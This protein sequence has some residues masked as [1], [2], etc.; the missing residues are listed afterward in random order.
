MLL[1]LLCS[2]NYVSYNVKVAQIMGLNTAVYLSELIN[3]N[4]KAINKDKIDNNCFTINRQYIENR[5]TISIE[6]QLKLDKKLQ[7]VGILGRNTDNSDMVYIDVNSL[8]NMIA[9]GDAK[10]LERVTKLTKLKDV[11]NMKVGKMTQKQRD[12]ENCKTAISTT[13]EELRTALCGWIEGVFAR[14]N[15]FLSKRA[16][17]IFQNELYKYTNGDLDL[18]LKLV[19]ISTVGGYRNFEWAREEFETK[20]ADSFRRQYKQTPIKVKT[21]ESVGEVFE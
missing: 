19:D 17:T 6:E 5:T 11:G 9:A 3:I 18:A 16:V 20:H 13:N 21:V 2:D 12:I 10:L 1:D 4:R 14:P 8:T 15:G 7:D